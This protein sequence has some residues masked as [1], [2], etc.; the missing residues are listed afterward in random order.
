MPLLL[1][2]T[3]VNTSCCLVGRLCEQLG[4]VAC[5]HVHMQDH[6]TLVCGVWPSVHKPLATLGMQ[7]RW[8]RLHWHMQRLRQQHWVCAADVS[9]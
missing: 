4:M 5:V 3:A 1:S 7:Q 9:K 2:C 8:V 6:C